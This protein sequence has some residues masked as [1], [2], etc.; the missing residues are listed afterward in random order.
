MKRIFKSIL[1]FVLIVPFA[2]LLV[3]CGGNKNLNGK[4]YVFDHVEVT[5]T[6]LKDEYEDDFKSLIMIFSEAE[7]EYSNGVGNQDTYDYKIAN[8]KLFIKD[9]LEDDFSEKAYAEVDGKYL[10]I[11]ETNNGGTAKIYLKVK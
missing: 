3:A 10:I 7:V 4:T 8:G 6:L 1:A 2:F 5:G 9:K 11:S